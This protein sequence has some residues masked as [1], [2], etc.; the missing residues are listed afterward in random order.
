[1]DIQE[2]L[3]GVNLIQDGSITVDDIASAWDKSKCSVL[4]ELSQSQADRGDIQG[5]LNTANLIT[6][7]YYKSQALIKIA[8]A[9]AQGGDIPGALTSANLITD[10]WVKSIALSE[11]AKA[12]EVKQ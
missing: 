6:N 8:Q 11:I 5:A 12:Q 9:Q 2:A 3:A 10:P 7:S 1:M 4:H